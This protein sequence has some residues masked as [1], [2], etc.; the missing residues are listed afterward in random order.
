MEMSRT[1]LGRGHT[2][3]MSIRDQ[4]SSLA[5]SF[6]RW[7]AHFDE[8]R[9][10]E[11]LEVLHPPKVESDHE[12]NLAMDSQGKFLQFDTGVPARAVAKDDPTTEVPAPPRRPPTPKSSMRDPQSDQPITPSPRPGE[13]AGLRHRQPGMQL[14]SEGLIQNE[15]NDT[16]YNARNQV[17]ALIH[18]RYAKFGDSIATA[19]LTKAFLPN[20]LELL[21]TK[22][23]LSTTGSQIRD[24]EQIVAFIDRNGIEAF[25]R[26]TGIRYEAG[27]TKDEQERYVEKQRRRRTSENLSRQ[28]NNGGVSPTMDLK[29][30]GIRP[31]NLRKQD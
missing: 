10:Q 7:F 1:I 21:L 5:L 23:N 4:L 16:I 6:R 13:V 14:G 3:I 8:E 2:V 11:A 15:T 25:C 30:T 9:R 24:H 29:A 18:E 26:A 12:D 28:A 17:V 22:L 19:V 31:V 20:G 27:K